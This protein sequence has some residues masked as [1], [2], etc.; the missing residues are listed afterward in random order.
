[1]PPIQRLIG[2]KESQEIRLGNKCGSLQK[3]TVAVLDEV[4]Q[5]RQQKTKC[6]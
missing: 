2:D 6:F 5:T 4:G 1:M 3:P